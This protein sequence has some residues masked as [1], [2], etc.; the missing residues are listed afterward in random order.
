MDIYGQAHYDLSEIKKL[1]NNQATR[2][3]TDTA[4]NDAVSLRYASDSDMVQRVQQLKESEVYKTM[5]AYRAPGTWQ[6]VYLT[7]DGS[8]EIYIKIQKSLCGKKG[9]IIAFKKST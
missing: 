9:I 1:L 6:D 4:R 8:Q 7:M 3:V 5:E 2:R